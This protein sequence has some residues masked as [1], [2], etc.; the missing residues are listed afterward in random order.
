MEKYLGPIPMEEDLTAGK[1]RR[2]IFENN[3]K[4]YT[5]LRSDSDL[6]VL[7]DSSY[8]SAGGVFYFSCRGNGV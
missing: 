3:G 2:S 4:T 8:V 1:R 5:V 6:L 7:G